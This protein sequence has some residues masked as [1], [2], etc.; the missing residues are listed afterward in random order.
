MVP[1]TCI[2]A[3]AVHNFFTLS[4]PAFLAVGFLSNKYF[5]SPFTLIICPKNFNCLSPMV[6]S[7][8]ILYLAIRIIT[9]LVFLSVHETF[10]ILWIYQG[11]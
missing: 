2:L 10:R 5:S 7:S 6:L 9:S 8:A 1:R 3:Q 11:S 4:S